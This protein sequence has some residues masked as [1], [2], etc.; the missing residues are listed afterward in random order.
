MKSM[1]EKLI[2]AL[3]EALEME[4]SDLKPEDKF[5][6]Y[7]NY[8]SLTELSVLAMLDSEFGIEIEMK[9]FNNY[10]TVEDLIGLVTKRSEN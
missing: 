8:S 2:F 7:E 6:N 9:E 10:F 3:A 4:P 1:K 5:R